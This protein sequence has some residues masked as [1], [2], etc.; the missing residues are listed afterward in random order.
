[1]AEVAALQ[2]AYYEMND[3]LNRIRSFVPQSV[4]VAKNRQQAYGVDLD[5]DDAELATNDGRTTD[6]RSG[7]QSQ[8][9]MRSGDG[10]RKG[11]AY[12]PSIVRSDP[13]SSE[14]LTPK[15]VA[16][17]VANAAGFTAFAGGSATAAN[18]HRTADAIAALLAAA[19]LAV[20][21]NGGVLGGF[22]GD[23][24]TATFNA[25]RP[26]S[27]P[28]RRACAAAV[29]LMRNDLGVPPMPATSDHD[30]APWLTDD[31]APGTPLAPFGADANHADR[32]RLHFQLGIAASRCLVGNAG[33]TTAKTFSVVGPA[34]PQAVFLERLSRLYGPGCRALTTARVCSDVSSQFRFRYV[35][36][37]VLPPRQPTLVAALLGPVG[38]AA[39]ARESTKKDDG[40]DD[41]WLYVL[42]AQAASDPNGRHNAAFESLSSGQLSG[43]AAY[44]AE[45]AR[46]EIPGALPVPAAL[47]AAASPSNNAA[48]TRRGDAAC[49]GPNTRAVCDPA[50]ANLLALVAVYSET[51]GGN[52]PA[53]TSSLADLHLA[54]V[55]KPV[56]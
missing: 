11:S 5:D 37:V 33:T 6:R 17:L 41:E 14:A 54:F 12:A 47:A 2:R 21:V 20:G 44:V 55:R 30:D 16:V 45:L 51:C 24:F 28:A 42:E 56:V 49:Q 39:D 32:P 1:M 46:S 9:S 18:A 43:C 35:D 4:L 53:P 15:L 38:D 26:C 27:A 52:G 50:T 3:E 23:H 13:L 40:N 7:S 22:H 36:H 8:R 48:A 19:E 29:E 34:F 25:V 31:A 10:S